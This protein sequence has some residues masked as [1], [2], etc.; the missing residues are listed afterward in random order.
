[1]KSII[2]CS[3][4][5]AFSTTFAHAQEVFFPEPISI[6]DVPKTTPEG[7]RLRGGK[8]KA[9]MAVLLPSNEI[10][11]FYGFIVAPGR[12]VA[13]NAYTVNTSFGMHCWT[14]MQPAPD[15]SATGI[16]RCFFEDLL[17]H[18]FP[19]KLPAGTYGKLKGA[20]VS[21]GRG[22]DGEVYRY[23]FGWSAGRFPDA[24]RLIDALRR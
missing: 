1:L 17:V 22:S 2:L 12:K 6:R 15:A 23:A 5:S 7:A 4:I 11:G 14:S 10:L 9:T 3:A 20:I 8:L 16:T 19:I 21:S 18:E 13:S 24:D